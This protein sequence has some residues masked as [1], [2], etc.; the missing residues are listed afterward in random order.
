[1]IKAAK[2]GCIIV[3]LFCSK[4]NGYAKPFISLDSLGLA[5][6]KQKLQNGTAPEG[7]LVAYNDLLKNADQLLTLENPTVTNKSLLP[8][9]K[10]KRDYLSISRYWWPN[11]NT[12]D[13]LPW[14]R[15]D[16]ETN[17]DTQT[18]AVD[19]RRLSVMSGGV[20]NLSLAYYF[21]G[22]ELYAK[23]AISMIKTWFI[24][25]KTHMKPHLEYAQSVPGIPEGRRSGILDGRSIV[26]N[27]P[28]A[29][30]LLSRSKHW[31]TEDDLK[32]TNWFTDYLTW[33]TES[34]LGK[35]GSKQTNNHGSWYKFQVASLALYLGNETMAKKMIESAQLSLDYHLN[36]QG[37]QAH[38]L[39]R[40]RS[41]FYSC[42]N[43]DALTAIAIIGDKIGMNMWHYESKEGKSLSLA[44]DY[45]TPLING[46]EWPH[47]SKYGPDPSYLIRTLARMANNSN[48]KEYSE[49]LTKILRTI[50]KKD[51]SSGSQNKA[52][53]ELWL[54]GS[55]D[56]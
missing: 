40:T 20:K 23:K 2:V 49:L 9:T 11:P 41:Y 37:G 12:L 5:N 53:N 27:V 35:K 44:V 25:E 29:I 51:D 22:N 3:F 47:P 33:L 24:D 10:D 6:V 14:V 13:S 4:V 34:E 19:R 45:L 30:N 54:L 31:S 55:I 28:D 17:P 39:A 21:S 18:N 15:K 26:M 48:S 52:L 16:G 7:T 36:E 46:E 42:F 1:M 56:Y 50:D 8:P 38:E 32:L 43:L